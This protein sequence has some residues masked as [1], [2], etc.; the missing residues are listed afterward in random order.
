MGEYALIT[1]ASGGLGKEFA[2]LA[3]QDGYDL[4][5]V[6]RREEKLLELAKDIK[7]RWNVEVLTLAI[8]L[9]KEQSVRELIEKTKDLQ[10]ECLINN[11]GFGYLSDYVESDLS[12]QKEL[13]RLNVEV[14]M[15]L[16]HHYGAKMK[17]AGKGYILNIASTAALSPGPH[18]STYFASKS[19]VLSFSEALHEELRKD[20]VR[21]S[22]LCPGPVDT[23]FEKNA[24]MKDSAMF[25]SLPVSKPDKIARK[26]YR[27]LKKGRAVIY[28]GPVTHW[29][30]F[31]SRIFPRSWMRKIIGRSNAK[32]VKS[33]KRS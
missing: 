4:I 28:A 14:P 6:A 10:V 9:Q 33:K 26:G 22:A 23:D 27:G 19:Y 17:E 31:F 29:M 1:G 16:T 30:A 13:L 7:E 25:H 5:L 18:M 15:E 3:A 24:N 11:A 20:G 21:V 2:Y 12:H 8:D 32:T